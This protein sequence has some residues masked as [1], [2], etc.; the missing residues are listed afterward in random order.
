MSENKY[1]ALVSKQAEEF[2]AFPMA[3]GF[4]EEGIARGMRS[5]G[6][7][8]S[9]R[10]KV[11]AF[12]DSGGFY[13]KEDQPK[14]RAMFERHAK[15]RQDAIEQDKTGLG[16]VQDMFVAVLSDTEYPYTGDASDALDR[17][18]YTLQDVMSDKRLLNGLEAAKKK[19]R[20]NMD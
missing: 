10:D 11:V 8:P 3:Y 13:R 9:E 12:G 4:G 19:L 17:L 15:E 20:C 1:R 7:D 6:L 14:L 2:Y 5:L 16:F 18:G